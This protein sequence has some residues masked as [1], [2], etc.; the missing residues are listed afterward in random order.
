MKSVDFLDDWRSDQC[1]WINGGVAKL[2]RGA[3]KCSYFDVDLP[4]GPSKEFRRHAYQLLGIRARTKVFVRSRSCQ[5]V[6]GSVFTTGVEKLV[7]GK[8]TCWLIACYS[9]CC[10]WSS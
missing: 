6:D 2:P 10:V 1:R 9:I 3:P 7:M 5:L 8:K 4:T